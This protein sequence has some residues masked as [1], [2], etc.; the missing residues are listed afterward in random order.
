MKPVIA[1]KPAALGPEFVKLQAITDALNKA[2]ADLAVPAGAKVNVGGEYSAPSGIDGAT[3]TLEDPIFGSP[4]PKA[5]GQVVQ[6][7]EVTEATAASSPA[8]A[9][10]QVAAQQPAPV[11]EPVNLSRIFFTGRSGA[12]K[13]YLAGLLG[14]AEFCIQDPILRMLSEEF[15]DGLKGQYPA[16]FVNLVIMWGE[17]FVSD[18]VPI[19]ATRFLFSSKARNLFGEDFGKPGF[20]TRRMLDAALEHDGQSVITTVTEEKQAT[21]LKEAGFTH[22]HIMCSNPTLQQR[23][24]RKG[25]NDNLANALDA[26][27]LKAISMQRDGAKLKA[28]WCDTVAPT[29]SARL[30]DIGGFLAEARGATNSVRVAGE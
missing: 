13:S 12:G 14:A 20:W 4:I 26:Q 30:Y 5:A 6:K 22:Y 15:G 21:A 16:D 25:A 17:G 28:I 27:V 1:P 24:K 8:G 18:K 3:T 11:A 2:R 23:A 9:I 19:T 29:L 7:S 10:Q